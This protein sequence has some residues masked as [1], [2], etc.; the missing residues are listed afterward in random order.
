MNNNSEKLNAISPC[1]IYC[2][3]C[4]AF[5]K[6]C[7][8]CP[9]SDKDQERKSK[10][11]CKIRNCCYNIKELDYCGYCDSYPCKMLNTKIINSHLNDRRYDYRHDVPTGFSILKRDGMEDFI[12]Y[13]AEKSKC[14]KCGGV[15]MFYSYKCNTCGIK[16]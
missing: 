8:G 14:P 7:K 11:N 9:S 3:A 1:G 5:G 12:K 16:I 10:W 2:K 4:P 6:S 15:I 13:H